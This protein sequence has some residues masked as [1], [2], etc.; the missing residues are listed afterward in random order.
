VE[1]DK[2][3]MNMCSGCFMLMKELKDLEIF[4]ISLVWL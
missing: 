2:W 4:S 3:H 1:N